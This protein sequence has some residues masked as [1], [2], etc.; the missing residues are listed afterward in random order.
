MTPKTKSYPFDSSFKE[1]KDGQ[2]WL[3]VTGVWS[4]LRKCP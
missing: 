1:D 4:A 3:T 2:I